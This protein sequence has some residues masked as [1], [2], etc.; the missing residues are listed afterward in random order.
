MK[1]LTK[2]SAGMGFMI[3]HDCNSRYG[4]RPVLV[5]AAVLGVL[6]TVGQPARGQIGA[7]PG[8]PLINPRGVVFSPATGKVYSVDE[9]K[10][11]VDI[12]D[13]AKGSTVRVRVGSKPV[14]IAV[15]DQTG[16]AYVVNLGD[17]TVS[18]L[19][20]RRDTV[21]A[22]VRVG[23]EPYAIA[24]N[25]K[26]GKVYVS[27]S[28]NSQI[29]EIDGATNTP[30]GIKLSSADFFAIDTTRNTL[31]L[32]GYES[33]AL[34]MLDGATHAVTK[35]PAGMHLWGITLDERTGTAY[36]A[37]SGSADVIALRAGAAPVIIPVGK[38]PCASAF[39]PKTN[40]L[41]VVNYGDDSLSVIDAATGRPKATVPVGKEP[42]AVAVDVAKNLIYV[43]N[44]HGNSVT[45]I[46]GAD[47]QVLATLAAGKNPYALA[48][49]PG[50]DKLHVANLDA[51]SFTVVDVA[52]VRSAA[53]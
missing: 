4:C 23:S 31:Y 29:T 3:D 18:V 32:T 11:A 52:H 38:I 6:M 34:T 10:G 49:N 47:N 44:T 35:R 51:R 16:T 5:V 2:F 48:I 37:R 25:S 17:G 9:A 19:D 43:A 53:R 39:N 46:D 13:D 8:N 28:D 20:G 45:V 22:T 26:T 14:S 41:Y 7:A 30:T 33:G 40:M 24:A 42:K 15:N 27:R 50:S 1:Y 36:V 21:V 12:S